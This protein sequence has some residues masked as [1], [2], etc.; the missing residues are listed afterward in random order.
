[1]PKP[2]HFFFE[3]KNEKQIFTINKPNIMK[4]SKHQQYFHCFIV[5]ILYPYAFWF[6]FLKNIVTI[7]I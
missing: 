4:K 1:M 3:N 6:S 7:L 5:G 2:Y